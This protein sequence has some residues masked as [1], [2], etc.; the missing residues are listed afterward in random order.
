MANIK[1]SKKRAKQN[2]V[3]RKRNQARKTA[4]KTA[5]KKVLVSLEEKQDVTK[6]VELLRAAESKIARAKGKGLIH[7]TT[8][9]RTMSRLAKKVSA[10]QKA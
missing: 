8:A 3:R 4:V 5:I 9:S 1:S 2:E 7:A 6:T 10:A